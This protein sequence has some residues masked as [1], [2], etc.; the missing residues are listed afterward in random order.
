MKQADLKQQFQIPRG[1]PLKIDAYDDLDVQ[2]LRIGLRH[3]ALI[4]KEGTLYMFGNGNW[5]V[6]GQGNEEG[7]RFDQPV[8][9]TKFSKLGLKVVDIA[10]GEF[11]SFALTD[12]GNVWTWGYPGKQGYF[13]WLYTQEIGALGHNNIEPKFTPTKVSFF[14]ENGIK[15]KSIS[16]GLYHCN[17]LSTAGDL[18]SWGRG[19]YGVLGNGSNQ[20]SLAPILNEDVQAMQEED[21]EG[22]QITSMDSADEYTM[23]KTANDSL[24]AWGKNDRGQMGTGAGIGIDMVECENVPT[25]V[26]LLDNQDQLKV[27]KAFAVGQNSMMSMD[28]DNNVYIAG[29]KLNYTP[30]QLQFDSSIL[31]VKDITQ[32]RCGRKHYILLDKNNDLFVW[33]NVF[34]EISLEQTEGFFK[35]QGDKLFN[36]S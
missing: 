10:L 18:Y 25:Q 22:Y 33:G 12:D 9:V 29:Q 15:I 14:E 23:I 7:A 6:L 26:D 30:K 16:A 31:D 13:N 24:F 27:G 4:S 3:S 17:A 36:G 34:T 11:H 2:V 5:G 21:K 1:V 32:M 35:Y 19:L 28:S 20:H 8:E